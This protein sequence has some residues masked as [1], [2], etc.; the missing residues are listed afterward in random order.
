MEEDLLRIKPFQDVIVRTA[1]KFDLPIGLIFAICKVESNFTPTAMRWEPGFYHKYIKPKKDE[2]PFEEAIGN[3]VSFGLMQIM[4][5]TARW[6]G[7]ERDL[8]GLWQPIINLNYGCKYLNK[9]R[10]RYE[11][12][13]DAIAAY[14]AGSVR[15]TEEG[16]YI[17]QPYVDKVLE[18]WKKYTE[19]IN[20]GSNENLGEKEEKE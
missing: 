3:A 4:G 20:G 18:Y 19:I 6:M 5:S 14:N 17:N 1:K 10:K 2:I 16:A 12:I 15:K 8:T 9:L 13:E 7:Y 11:K